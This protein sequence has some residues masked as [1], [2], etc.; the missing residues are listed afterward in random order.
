MLGGMAVQFIGAFIAEF[1]IHTF[2]LSSMERE[3]EYVIEE[4]FEMLGTIIVLT[5]VLHK[6]NL[7]SVGIEE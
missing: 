3:L 4:S 1:I 2:Q 5:G 7:A 6:I